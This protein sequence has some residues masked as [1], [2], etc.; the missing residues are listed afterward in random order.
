M[1]TSTANPGSL[2]ISDGVRTSLEEM[3]EQFCC[4]EGLVKDLDKHGDDTLQV[5]VDIAT[6]LL[7]W[8]GNASWNDVKELSNNGPLSLM[9]RLDDIAQALGPRL[10]LGK[11]IQAHSPVISCSLESNSLGTFILN[12]WT[13]QP[14]HT[15]EDMI[16]IQGMDLA[17]LG[18]KGTE[19]ISV[20]G[21]A[22]TN[23]TGLINYN[24]KGADKF[25]VADVITA[26]VFGPDGQISVPTTF[27]RRL[28]N[29]QASNSTHPRI[30]VCA[31]W[32]SYLR[33]RVAG[34]WS[35]KGCKTIWE[36]GQSSM[37]ASN[38]DYIT[39]HCNHTTNYAILMR[40]VP[41]EKPIGISGRASVGISD[42][43]LDILTMVG[44]IVSILALL[45]ALAFFIFFKHSTLDTERILIHCNLMGTLLVAMVV[46][47]ISTYFSGGT[48]PCKIFAGLLHY[49][50]LAVFCWMLV[51]SVH[52]YRLIVTV[53]GSER[54]MAKLYC[55]IGWGLPILIV[56]VSAGIK[57]THYGLPGKGCWLSTQN[58]FIWA[59]VGPACVIMLVNAVVLAMVI[60]TTVAA[61][62]GT[63]RDTLAKVKA[64][65]RSSLVLLP[66]LGITWG[67]GLIGH[68]SP[69]F[70]YTFVI[71]NSFQGFW[72]VIVCCLLNGEVR[73]AFHLTI[74]KMGKFSGTVDAISTT[75]NEASK[76]RE[77]ES[78]GNTCLTDV[79]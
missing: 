40:I 49:L 34:G 63:S 45:T 72:L 35:T 41:Y 17:N 67:V 61:S 38:G 15:E 71:L 42:R 11:Q 74:K 58:G 7:L 44:C 64:G 50:Y 1:Y 9:D 76:Q 14:F 68:V 21:A 79:D 60:R 77:K 73:Q 23:L 36:D 16:S 65:L 3:T 66:M 31:F 22:Y 78:K 5:A 10:T 20:L 75:G 30:P 56:G 24:Q 29:I 52:L 32:D 39:C 57:W 53:Y 62:K 28:S 46:F 33:G 6:E 59:F 51:E 12:N 48:I 19:R 13:Y 27:R 18:F 70:E 54:Q 37:E 55:A 47:M 4:L 2:S 26:T 25:I 8:N 69:V 43:I